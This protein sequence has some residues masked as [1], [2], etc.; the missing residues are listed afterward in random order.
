[1]IGHLRNLFG[2][3]GTESRAGPAASLAP[4][5]S[6]PAAAAQQEAADTERR[7]R[8][9][10]GEAERK[11]GDGVALGD[12][13]NMLADFMMK[14]RRVAEAE[15][16]LRR[17]LAIEEGTAP[18]RPDRLVMALT[19]LAAAAGYRGN[20]AEAESLYRRAAERCDGS[21][22]IADALAV[23]VMENL[24]VLLAEDRRHADSA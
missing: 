19:N 11:G 6:A 7:L 20:K 2:K 13:V 3:S 9:A 4:A 21:A 15:A 5:A 16:A 10:V 17:V 1:M 24:A 18:A 22:G 12:A 8:A 14:H 23:T